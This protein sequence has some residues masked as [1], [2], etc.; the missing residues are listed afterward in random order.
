MTP[1]EGL[2]A[3]RKRLTRQPP[4]FAALLH[5]HV[6]ISNIHSV[7]VAWSSPL[8]PSAGP[9]RAF[10]DPFGQERRVTGLLDS[11]AALTRVRLPRVAD[12]PDA[13]RIAVVVAGVDAVPIL[14]KTIGRDRPQYWVRKSAGFC[15]RGV[16]RALTRAAPA[17][18]CRTMRRGMR[19]MMPIL[20]L[21]KV[22]RD[23]PQ[24]CA[25]ESRA[26]EPGDDGSRVH[27]RPR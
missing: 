13:M 27:S 23:R 6:L 15:C 17:A 18:R 20:S 21:M 7:A 16:W 1:G 11:V 25:R 14:P 12:G 19:A 10:T 8:V 2:A 26:F 24:L 5:P 9:A 3:V 22:S 4:S